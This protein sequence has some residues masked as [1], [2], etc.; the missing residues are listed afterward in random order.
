MI[1][2]FVFNISSRMKRKYPTELP[3]LDILEYS[4]KFIITN[5]LPIIVIILYGV[6]SEN[7]VNVLISLGSF[8]LLR[9]FSGGYHIKIPELCILTSAALIISISEIGQKLTEH[10]MIMG[11]V[12]LLM[13]M[14]YAP[15]NIRMQTLIPEKYDILLK[16][17]SCGIIIINIYINDAIAITAVFAQSLLLIRPLKGGEKE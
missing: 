13:V 2:K 10:T 15:S 8:S 11:I 17:A 7:L 14:V 5:V 6:V 16:L 9:M 3:E 12:S 1:N 4:L